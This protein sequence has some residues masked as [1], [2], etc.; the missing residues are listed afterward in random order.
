MRQAV[1][2]S[3]IFSLFVITIEIED[4]TLVIHL[5]CERSLALI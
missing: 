1:S 3:L 5:Y 4:C 2:C